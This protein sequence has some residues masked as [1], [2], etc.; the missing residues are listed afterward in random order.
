MRSGRRCISQIFVLKQLVEKYREKRKDLY[1]V[2]V[3]PEK[4]Y[5]KVGREE[6]W[7][8]INK[9]GVDGYLRDFV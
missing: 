1:F 3:D 4:A 2:F 9:C 5:D 6:L 7:R 8:V